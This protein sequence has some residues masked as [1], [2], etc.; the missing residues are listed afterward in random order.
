MIKTSI[1]SAVAIVEKKSQLQVKLQLKAACKRSLLQVQL[2]L[3]QK[4]K[5]NRSCKKSKARA[6]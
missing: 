1:A 6:S 4:K 5:K 2:Q 3:G